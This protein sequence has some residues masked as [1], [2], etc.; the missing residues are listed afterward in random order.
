MESGSRI[1][2]M[3][4]IWKST[5]REI[6]QSFG[7]FIA[8]LAIV[9][10]GVGFFAGLKVT[11]SAMVKTTENYLEEHGFYDYR[12]LST[13]GFEQEE[14]EYLRQKADVWAAEGAVSF[15]IIYQNATGNE[16]VAKVHSITERLNKLELLKGRMPEAGR[17]NLSGCGIEGLQNR[18][19]RIL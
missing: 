7:R 6:K 12:L 16:S 14:A 9:A 11:K 4:T 17:S 8:I 5:L 18:Q 19:C 13:M 15:D 1:E 2:E 3:K 10:L